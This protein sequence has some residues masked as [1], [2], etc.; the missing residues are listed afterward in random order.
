MFYVILWIVYSIY[1]VLSNKLDYC[2]LPHTWNPIGEFSDVIE[3]LVE[4]ARDEERDVGEGE[5]LEQESGRASYGMVPTE[6]QDAHDVPADSKDAESADDV[7]VDRQ[8]EPVEV[9]QTQRR[10]GGQRRDRASRW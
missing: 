7:D 8:L 6:D 9:R 4:D 2:N 3:C 5:H 1:K 10:V